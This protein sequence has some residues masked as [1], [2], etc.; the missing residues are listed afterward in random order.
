MVVYHRVICIDLSHVF[1]EWNT[2]TNTMIEIINYDQ[3]SCV[4]SEPILRT[5]CFDG[6]SA[7]PQV[8]PS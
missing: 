5:C 2:C 8:K 7:R 1:P 4:E 3:K 6:K